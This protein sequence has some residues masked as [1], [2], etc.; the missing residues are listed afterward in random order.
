MS[1]T[2]AT[3]KPT[4]NGGSNERSSAGGSLK[5]AGSATAKPALPVTAKPATSTM[6]KPA[7]SATVKPSSSASATV[8]PST[9]ATVKPSTSATVKP[10]TSATVKP[11]I[12]T[13][14]SSTP[15]DGDV[16][17]SNGPST[18]MQSSSFPPDPASSADDGEP[19]DPK[20][21][22]KDRAPSAAQTLALEL[23]A[24]MDGQ[25]VLRHA[26]ALED[27]REAT[28]NQAARLI[29]ELSDA[30]PELLVPLIERFSRLLISK[31]KRVVASSANALAPLSRI[32]PAKV[33][34]QLPLLTQNWE[35]TTEEGKDGLVR[36]FAGL[37]TASVAYQKRLE[38]AL[39]RALGEAEPK[40]L[41][42]WTEIVLPALKGEPH[43][44]A[45][46]VVEERLPNIPRP[47]AQKIADF[48]GIKLR[49]LMR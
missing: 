49:P 15:A 25:A 36:T 37:C 14:N 26:I 31:N 48:L 35:H 16:A 7:S 9:S 38:P 18:A 11:S 34:K 46:A 22:A 3:K 21:A 5:H 29:Q 6:V 24:S 1:P 2:K 45:R 43:A 27:D 12:A 10:S 47:Q 4:A 44:R 28:A 17:L 41:I 33:A 20:P 39:A 8:K 42:R 40:L 19:K 30:K 13:P 32:A 23:I